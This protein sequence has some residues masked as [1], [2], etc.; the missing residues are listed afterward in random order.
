VVM[1]ARRWRR[2]GGGCRWW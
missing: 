2:W 1:T